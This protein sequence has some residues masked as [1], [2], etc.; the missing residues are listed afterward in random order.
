MRPP[1]P[2]AQ[3][4]SVIPVSLSLSEGPNP[5][6]S[7]RTLSPSHR[8]PTVAGG[9]PGASVTGWNM[10]GPTRRGKPGRIPDSP[11]ITLTADPGASLLLSDIDFNERLIGLTAD[12]KISLTIAKSASPPGVG[13]RPDLW[14][15]GGSPEGITLLQPLYGRRKGQRSRENS[16]R[17]VFSTYVY[18]RGTS[19][20]HAWK[21]GGSACNMNA[22]YMFCGGN[23]L[24][25][26]VNS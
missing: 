16:L 23:W 5:E 10:P 8:P 12:K 18:N 26:I 15:F 13:I 11:A 21:M 14:D 1:C 3:Q 2:L 6:P 22:S 7:P 25:V 4:C 9:Y 20:L 19:V 24:C 17:Q